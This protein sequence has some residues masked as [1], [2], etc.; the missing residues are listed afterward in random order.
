MRELT[1]NLIEEPWIRCAYINGEKKKVSL[2][3]LLAEA[4]QISGFI[5]PAPVITSSL[6]RHLLLPLLMRIFPLRDDR[7]WQ[8]LWNQPCFDMP[9]IATYFDHFKD[10]FDLFH[11][12]RPFYQAADPRVQRKSL[13]KMIPHLA[14]G[15]NA[16]LFDH[17]VEERGVTLSPE[18]AAQYVIALQAYGLGGLSGIEEKFT[19]APACP[20]ISFFVQGANLYQ[21]LLL[22]LLP[23]DYTLLQT[24]PSNP[25]Y[26]DLPTWEMDSPFE[27][28]AT[29]RG[30]LDYLTWQNR[31]VLLFPEREGDGPIR[32]R[33]MTEG[34]GLR[35]AEDFVDGIKVRDPFQ[36]Y[37]LT[38]DNK[39]LVVRF[40]EGRV[41]WRDSSA[42]LQFDQ[43][44]GLLAPPILF[45]L[46][47]LV[48]RALLPRSATYQVIALGMAANK[49]KIL[50]YGQEA[51]PLP[52]E[53][54]TDADLVGDLRM[55]LEKA[56]ALSSSLFAS[57]S[58]MAET[59]IDP[60][61]EIMGTKPKKETI[62]P[63]RNHLEAGRVFWS[64]LEPGFYKLIAGLPADA[65]QAIA[66][67]DDLLRRQTWR[68]HEYSLSLAGES[69]N[70]K[71]AAVKAGAI[72]A[73][74]INRHLGRKEGKYAS[75]DSA[76]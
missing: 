56:D 35:L 25:A 6:F 75:T 14:S 43:E 29:P 53:Y 36:Y 5:T 60:D 8:D 38:A 46:K 45:W 11:P 74:G 19:A 67:W 4:P 54:L 66:E 49:S 21:T 73:A 47:I 34:P 61:G 58:A 20:G 1:Y 27:P 69:I 44:K 37:R 7:D 40:S 9:S 16:T 68:A 31:R 18:E 52:A 17:S 41:L 26:P 39:P 57:V 3:V 51:L 76:S 13:L 2:S 12:D 10:R 22:N 42:L 71:K 65:T 72:I 50:F 70:A 30:L 59:L 32:V 62:A 23:I 33:E 55:A 28:R 24:I 63:L 64:E 48:N 15:N